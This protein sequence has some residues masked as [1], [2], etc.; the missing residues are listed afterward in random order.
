LVVLP[1]PALRGVPVEVIADGYTVSYALS[2]TLFAY[3]RNKPRPAGAG[4]L[5]VADPVFDRPGEKKPA[6]PPLPPRGP[7]LTAVTPH[8][9][10]ANARLQA[11]DVLLKYAGTELKTNADLLKLIEAHA[12]DKQV[13]VAV[14]RDGRSGDR[15]VGPGRLGIVMAKDPAPVA[16]ADQ[17][18]T[19]D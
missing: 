11:G 13:T 9:T 10:A 17:R 14:W 16:L 12:G 3:L 18:R 6:P 7:L 15:T 4:L 2:G 1:S 5:A 19:D 8:P